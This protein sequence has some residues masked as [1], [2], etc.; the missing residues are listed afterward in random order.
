[1]LGVIAGVYTI[2]G[3]LKAVVYTDAVQAILLFAGALMVS[4]LSFLAVGGSWADITAAVPESDLSVILPATDPVMPWPGLVTGVFLLGFY[5]WGTN[6]FM[7]QRTLG[8]RNLNHG[9]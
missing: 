3:G 9:R 4:V 5:F 8:A 7:V 2:A 6:Q 1:M